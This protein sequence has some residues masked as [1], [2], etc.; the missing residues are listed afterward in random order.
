[1]DEYMMD[2]ADNREVKFMLQLLSK[3]HSALVR[4]KY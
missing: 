3:T 1:M 4:P 2:T